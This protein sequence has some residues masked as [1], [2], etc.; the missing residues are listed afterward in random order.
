MPY[1]SI[2]TR[3]YSHSCSFHG[4]QW[5]HPEFRS[6]GDALRYALD[7]FRC[8]SDEYEWY[9]EEDGSIERSYIELDHGIWCCTGAHTDD[10]DG[11]EWHSLYDMQFEDYWTYVHGPDPT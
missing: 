3:E 9:Y 8:P 2:R 5:Y 7:I 11:G 6:Y 10:D 1:L 4:S